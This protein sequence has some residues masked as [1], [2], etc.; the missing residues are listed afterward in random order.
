MLTQPEIDAMRATVAS[1]LPD[2]AAIQRVQRV[3]DGGGSFTETWST[4]ARTRARLS[5]MSESEQVFAERVVERA[6]WTLTL[7]ASVQVTTADRVMV[8]PRVFE[9]LGVVSARSWQLGM[10]LALAEVR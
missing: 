6:D 3:A 8:G 9:V 5:P 1:A 7:E 4:V 10:R 2:W